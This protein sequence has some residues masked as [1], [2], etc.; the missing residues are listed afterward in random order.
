MPFVREVVLVARVVVPVE[1]ALGAA[2]EEAAALALVIPASCC[3]TVELKV[4]VI[5]ARVNLAENER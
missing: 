1:L 5:P 2:V 3:W 4:P